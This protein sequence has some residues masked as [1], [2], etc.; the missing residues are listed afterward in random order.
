MLLF[1]FLPPNG[2]SNYTILVLLGFELEDKNSK[3]LTL[4]P[5]Q[6]ETTIY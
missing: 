5:N 4:I 2:K 3:L 6:K 1:K